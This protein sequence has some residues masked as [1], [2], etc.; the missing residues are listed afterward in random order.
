M[1]VIT[2]VIPIQYQLSLLFSALCKLSLLSSALY[3]NYPYYVVLYMQSVLIIECFICKLSLLLR[4][5]MQT[6]LIIKS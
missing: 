4:L 3:A 5:Y 2:I 6:I 1:H